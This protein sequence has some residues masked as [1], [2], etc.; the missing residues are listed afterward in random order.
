MANLLVSQP[1][2]DGKSSEDGK[3]RVSSVVASYMRCKDPL[4]GRRS[5]FVICFIDSNTHV[6]NGGSL[7]SCIDEERS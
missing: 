1:E 7:G 4:I 2:L 3:S 5:G 6:L